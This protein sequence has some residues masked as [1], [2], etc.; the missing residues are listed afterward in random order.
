MTFDLQNKQ[1]P[2]SPS[3]FTYAELWRYRIQQHKRKCALFCYAFLFLCILYSVWYAYV[4][5]SSEYALKNM[6][7]HWTGTDINLAYDES[8][9]VPLGKQ[10][11]SCLAK[12]IISEQAKQQIH[13]FNSNPDA[14]PLFVAQPIPPSARPAIN[15]TLSQNQAML[16]EWDALPHVGPVRYPTDY[17]QSIATDFSHTSHAYHLEKLLTLRL[18]L[19]LEKDN[20]TAAI[21]DLIQLIKLNDSLRL[22]PSFHAQAVLLRM[23][24]DLAAHLATIISLNILDSTQLLRLQQALQAYPHNDKPIA[25]S[26]L[27]C[28]S[29]QGHQI[30]SMSHANVKSSISNIDSEFVYIAWQYLGIK[31]L[32]RKRFISLTDRILEQAQSGSSDFNWTFALYKDLP[33]IYYVT[34]QCTPSPHIIRYIKKIQS[35]RIDS[36]LHLAVAR[37]QLDHQSPPQNATQLVPDYINELPSKEFLS[38]V[39]PDQQ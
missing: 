20:R 33:K 30:F 5:I 34:N 13:I 35:N 23:E 11:A 10:Y 24:S 1:P 7:H 31:H 17:N 28:A 27:A 16:A 18:F 6:K 21:N 3:D 2:P 32:D 25:Y 22:E 26:C 38:S 37:Y 15:A 29:I 39:F 12:I 8:A 4:F 36:I 19:H 9:S 14:Q